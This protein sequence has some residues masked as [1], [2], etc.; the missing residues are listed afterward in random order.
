MSTATPIKHTMRS[1]ISSLDIATLRTKKLSKAV[2]KGLKFED[3]ATY[4]WESFDTCVDANYNHHL[5][6]NASE[7]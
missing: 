5:A 1:W 7:K 2:I 6:S 4:R 3:N